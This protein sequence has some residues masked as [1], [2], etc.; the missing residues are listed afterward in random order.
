MK[1]LALAAVALAGCPRGK[2]S[3]PAA[4]RDAGAR[5][6]AGDAAAP[7][8]VPP[9]PPLPEV[10]LGLPAST[11]PAEATPD[12]VA[13][14]AQLFAPLGCARC[15]VPEHGFAGGMD[16][17]GDGKPNLRRTPALVNLAWRH[18]FGWDGRYA[19][20]DNLLAAHVPGQLGQPLAALVAPLAIDERSDPTAHVL[21]ARVGGEPAAAAL[22]G[23]DAYMVTRY[24]GHAPWDVAERSAAPPTD[25]KAGYALFT[26][27]AQCAVCHPPPLYTD[28]GYHRLGLVASHDEGRGRVDPTAAGAFATPTVRG[29][30]A[31][32]A[33][34]H[35]GS[36]T[37][38]DAA[39]DWHLAGGVG[40]GA[41]PKIIDPALRPIALSPDERAA[42]G[43][44]VRSLSP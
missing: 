9:A 40:Q 42:L 4:K 6:V 14:G 30:A 20:L 5:P 7:A 27:K 16:R 44:F 3:E 18:A 28:G 24:S 39:I 25:L 1:A 15:H 29:A 32:T 13:L 38:L 26:G 17:A 34:F 19:S 12:A 37:S 33:F 35:D 8:V 43:A 36:A 11:L 10:P 2:P 22:R 21:L 23:L 41:D 31:R